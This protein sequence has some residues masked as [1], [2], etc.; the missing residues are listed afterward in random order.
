MAARPPRPTVLQRELPQARHGRAETNGGNPGALPPRRTAQGR[1]RRTRRLHRR[2]RQRGKRHRRPMRRMR[3]SRKVER[4]RQ[5]AEVLLRE[6]PRQAQ[7]EN[8]NGGINQGL[9]NPP[10]PKPEI[11]DKHRRT[12]EEIAPLKRGMLRHS[13]FHLNPAQRNRESVFSSKC[14]HMRRS[15]QICKY[16]RLTPRQRNNHATGESTARNSGGLQTT[17]R[18][19]FSPP[20]AIFARAI[21]C[22]QAILPGHEFIMPKNQ[23]RKRRR[24]QTGE[25]TFSPDTPFISHPLPHSQSEAGP[26]SKPPDQ[27][28]R[29]L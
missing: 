20:S 13:P 4:T 1:H 25:R 9:G 10:K 18:T 12:Q 3:R 14:A 19:I 6:V 16:T 11:G 22:A 8:Q 29:T 15:R 26:L 21:L 28:R 24:A 27:K 2:P 7:Q 23:R 17:W 5:A